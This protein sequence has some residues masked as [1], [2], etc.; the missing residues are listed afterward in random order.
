MMDDSLQVGAITGNK[1]YMRPAYAPHL[2]LGGAD[3]ENA[4]FIVVD[5]A[6]LSFPQANYYIHGIIGF[7]IIEAFDEFTI[8]KNDSMH[9]PAVKGKHKLNNMV[10][11]NLTPIV[12]AQ[13]EGKNLY[14]SFDTGAKETILYQSYYK[15]FEGEIKANSRF[16]EVNMGGAGGAIKVN[17]YQ[18]PNFKASIGGKDVTLPEVSILP[19]NLINSAENLYGNLGQDVIGQ[20]NSMTL[21][22]LSMSLIFE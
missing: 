3:I 11:E 4:V 10:L 6:A 19:K 13:T 17:V 12:C 7:P 1:V 9:I 2:N 20:F 21:N 18:F 16:E 22:F 14:F 8:F 15:D 5:D